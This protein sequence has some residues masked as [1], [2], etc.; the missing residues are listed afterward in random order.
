M[1]IQQLEYAELKHPLRP[2][3]LIMYVR[4]DPLDKPLSLSR[5]ILAQHL[6]DPFGNRPALQRIHAVYN[7]YHT[8]RIELDERLAQALAQFCCVAFVCCVVEAAGMLYG[9]P[10]DGFDF[11]FEDLYL[12]VALPEF[13][14]CQ[15]VEQ[16]V[17]EAYVAL[18]FV[19]FVKGT[20]EFAPRHLF[21]PVHIQSFMKFNITI[22]LRPVY[23]TIS[24]EL[25][26]LYIY[27]NHPGRTPKSDRPSY[28]LH[29]LYNSCS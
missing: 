23:Q 25:T 14:C 5:I 13:K 7:G 29:R 22:T 15:L 4:A 11:V 3:P 9:Q 27:T 19:G 1:P 24:I 8:L 16:L 2:E 21:V 17:V 6:T 26:P 10:L 20:T 28:Y 18:I 12:A